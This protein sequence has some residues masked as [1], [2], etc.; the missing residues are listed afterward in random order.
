MYVYH[1]IS[2]NSLRASRS[3]VIT[4]MSGYVLVPSL[5]LF[6]LAAEAVLSERAAAV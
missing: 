3:L 5:D 6:R 2:R 1:Y 4:A